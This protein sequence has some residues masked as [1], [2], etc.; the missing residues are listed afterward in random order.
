MSRSNALLDAIA[1][2]SEILAKKCSSSNVDTVTV[3]RARV[4]VNET[5]VEALT[6]VEVAATEAEIVQVPTTF[7]RPTSTED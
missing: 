4:T 7:N 5:R 6:C 1:D 2:G 3:G